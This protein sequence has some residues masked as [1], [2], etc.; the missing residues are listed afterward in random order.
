MKDD[1]A[2]RNQGQIIKGNVPFILD[3]EGTS[4]SLK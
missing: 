3:Y 1:A 2:E 4:I